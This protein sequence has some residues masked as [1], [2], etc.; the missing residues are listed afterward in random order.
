MT[1]FKLAKHIFIVFSLLALSISP[2]IGVNAQVDCDPIRDGIPANIFCIN[3]NG[4]V[5]VGTTSPIDRLEIQFQ[6]ESTERLLVTRTGEN[7]SAILRLHE[8]SPIIQMDD[9]ANGSYI[10]G[11]N[12]TS[13]LRDAGA[14]QFGRIQYDTV[15]DPNPIYIP[16][17][18]IAGN[19]NVGID[20]ITPTLKLDIQ[21]DFGRNN[22]P[23]TLNLWGS[24]VGDTG[25]QRGL[26]LQ[27]G[28]DI[29]TFNGNDRVGI[30]TTAPQTTLDVRGTISPE[31]LRISGGAD[32]AEPFAIA[33]KDAIKPG[34]VVA[35]DPDN[36]GQLRISEEAYD[37]T[38]VGVVSGAGGID[39]GLILQQAGMQVEDMHPV[40]LTG[41]VYVW[42]DAAEGAIQ[43]GD[44]LTTSNTP[45]HAMKVTDHDQAQ[46]ATLGKATS[47]LDEGQGLVLVLITLQ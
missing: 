24:R 22:G 34:M 1:Q 21:G 44:F 12:W 23:A 37:R 10:R 25:T 9:G 35:I 15:E 33:S 31:I 40:A 18:H 30:G 16:R 3:P 11:H 41:R 4:N 19:G 43:P 6:A 8:S 26:F 20:T 36:P 38:V 42:A 46:G 5:G 45:G 47:V 27:S 14:L 39:P 32:I 13:E 28:T 7:K 29:V 17:V 2:D